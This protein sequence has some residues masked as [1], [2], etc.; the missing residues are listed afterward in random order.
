LILRQLASVRATPDDGGDEIAAG[1]AI[2]RFLPPRTAPQA[3]LELP[4]IRFPRETLERPAGASA[5]R[6]ACRV[7]AELRA[8]LLPRLEAYRS[9]G[10]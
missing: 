3:K 8:E 7:F 10:R 6:I 9:W 2:E 1:R 4:M 5:R